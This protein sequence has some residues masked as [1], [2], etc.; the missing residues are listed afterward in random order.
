[1]II[2]IIQP[3]LIHIIIILRTVLFGQQSCWKVVQKGVST[4]IV[5]KYILILI[6]VITIFIF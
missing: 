5:S 1:M 3:V 2:I 4:Y 6:Y